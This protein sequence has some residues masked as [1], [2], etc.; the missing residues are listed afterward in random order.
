MIP[1]KFSGLVTCI[2]AAGMGMFVA[3]WLL[4]FT[5]IRTEWCNGSETVCVRDWLSALSGWIAAI[6]ALIAAVITVPYLK[7]QAKE[8]KRQTDFALGDSAPT[9]DVY[10]EDFL[11][12]YFR[13]VNWNRRTLLLDQITSQGLSLVEVITVNLT[14]R[15]DIN[16]SNIDLPDNHE[17]IF[18]TAI[19]ITGFENRSAPPFACTIKARVFNLAGIGM[20]PA[21]F[22]VEG[23][24]LGEHHEKIVLQATADVRPFWPPTN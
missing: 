23:R 13:I 10:A 11:Y 9:F 1:G 4:D 2:V 12:V 8:A 18:N 21:I 3:V 16:L 19:R 20:T 5:L 14:K 17:P 7:R 24:L 22:K 6:G 15:G